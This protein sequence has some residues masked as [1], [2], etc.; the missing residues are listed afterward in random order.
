MP[1]RTDIHRILV[2]GSGPI[3]IGQASEFDYSGTQAC[4]AL[5]AEGLEVVLV[6]SNPATIMTDPEIADRT[7]VEPLTP[8]VLAQIIE[9]ERPDALLPTVGGQTALNL[10]VALGENGTLDKYGVQLI[11]AS[12][13]AIKLAEDRL[14]F[15]DAMREIG[16]DVPRSHYCRSLNEALA[17]VDDIGFPAIIRPSFTLG[18]V[19][20]GIAYNVE[21]FRE[22]VSRGIEMS[23]V[24]EILLEE[25]VIGWKEFELEVMRDKADN[26]V[27]ICSIENVDPMGVHTG[28]SITVAPALTLTDREY[29]RMR[30]L[31]R[32]IIRRV[33][34][35]TGGSNIQFAINPANGRIIVIEMNPRVSRS[36]ALASKATGFPIA[37]IA[38]KLALG[39]HL[40]EIP[41]DITRLTPASF[42]P[43]IDYVVVKVPRWAFEKFPRA[44]RTLTTQMKSVGEVMA[45]GRTFKEA[46]MK[47]FRSL[48]LGSAGLLFGQPGAGG[49][50]GLTNEEEQGALQRALSVPNDRRM[51]ALFRALDRGWSVSD[52]H[53]LT[54]IDPW[55][56]VQFSEIVELQRSA[57]LVGLRGM[58]TDMLRALKRAG[59]ADRELATVL[60]TDEEA[61]PTDPPR[62]RAQAVVQTDRHLRRRIRIVHAIS[63][64]NLRAGMRSRSDATAEGCDSGQRPEP[65]RAGDRV[66]LLLLS[67]RVRASGRGI[68]DRHG[69]LQSRNGF[70]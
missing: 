41:N 19:G 43:T 42:E 7:Y 24:H 59:I 64:R 44:D 65:D 23:P 27:V 54:K 17:A 63:V 3:V 45:I 38:A 21:E 35:E 55:F 25:S 2:I 18:G 15:R 51:W 30:D 14:L 32:R 53:D 68:R 9:R 34:V 16:C 40:D 57:A 4:K 12:I 20:G 60:G 22:L 62:P 28:D 70:D 67:C 66:R 69:Q 56:L 52:L 37:K 36:S 29:Q 49:S 8:E 13:E 61:V 58:S 26:F 50:D 47:A 39:Y 48:E 31:G 11:G 5:K 10:A 46:F 6:N 1:K 33:G